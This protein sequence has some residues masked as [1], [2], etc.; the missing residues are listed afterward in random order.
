MIATNDNINHIQHKPENLQPLNQFT[1][2]QYQ[3]VVRVTRPAKSTTQSGTFNA[4]DWEVTWETQERWEN[5][6]M[7]WA[8]TYVH[9]DIHYDITSATIP[10]IYN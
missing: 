5:P 3:R 7:G 10:K 8:S 2:A 4:R 1:N 9:S 6:L